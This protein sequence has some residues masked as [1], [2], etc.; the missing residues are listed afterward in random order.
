V[1][2]YIARHRLTTSVML[3]VLVSREEKKLEVILIAIYKQSSVFE[4]MRQTVP[5]GSNT[6]KRPLSFLP[7]LSPSLFPPSLPYLLTCPYFLCF[8]AFC[9]QRSTVCEIWCV[10]IVDG[11]ATSLTSPDRSSHYVPTSSSSVLLVSST[12]PT[13]SPAR[14]PGQVISRSYSHSAVHWPG[15]TLELFTIRY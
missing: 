10:T 7:S 2:I 8:T 5:R 1:E 11:F 15:T 6:N 3:N 14:V 9:C 12:A 4:W 13:T